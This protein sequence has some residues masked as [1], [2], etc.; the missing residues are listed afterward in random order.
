MKKWSMGILVIMLVFA[1]CFYKI[2]SS[3]SVFAVSQVDLWDEWEQ[4]HGINVLKTSK[5][6]YDVIWASAQ[7]TSENGDWTHDIY[8]MTYRNG[9]TIKKML[10]SAPEAQE[11]SSASQCDDGH[12]LVTFEDGHAVGD[13]G[14]MQ[15]YA[16]FDQNLQPVVSYNPRQ[17]IIQAGGHSGHVASVHNTFV[18]ASDEGWVNHDGIKNRGTGKDIY[19]TTMNS[20]G[21]NKKI[22]KIANTSSR[23]DWPLVAGSKNV[24]FLL[25]QRIVPKRNYTKLMMATFNLKTRKV[26][27]P[28]AVSKI[29]CQYYNYSVSYMPKV[30]RFILTA[31]DYHGVGHM[32]LYN[33][34]GKQLCHKSGL[35]R[36]SR[37]SSPAVANNS[38]VYPTYKKSLTLFKVTYKSIKKIKTKKT[39]LSW[40]SRGQAG[41]F[42]ANGKVVFYALQK[43]KLKHMKMKI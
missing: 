34:N 6:G 7:K 11:P 41:V 21:N 24:A 27:H 38:I 4:A 20:V 25:W 42:D 35:T 19:M 36:F 43:N 37:E 8:G 15:R 22:F 16:I 12:I 5:K 9:H 18:I 29:K 31:T 32:F 26:S 3:H 2:H 28:K 10:V 33:T 39:S 14:I 30:N 40:S 23:Y 17:T 1:L 13:Y